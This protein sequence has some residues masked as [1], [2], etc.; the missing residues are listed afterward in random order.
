MALSPHNSELHD[1]L[2]SQGAMLTSEQSMLHC[3]WFESYGQ[4]GSIGEGYCL[5]VGRL[6]ASP[7]R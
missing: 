1:D 7:F 6:Q 3:Q 5:A 4:L 2:L